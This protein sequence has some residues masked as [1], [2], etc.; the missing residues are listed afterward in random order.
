MQCFDI[1]AFAFVDRIANEVGGRIT[2]LLEQIKSTFHFL[3][4]RLGNRT[5]SRF[6]SKYCVAQISNSHQ[7]C[8]NRGQ[9]LHSFTFRCS[10]CVILH[11]RLGLAKTKYAR[12]ELIDVKAYAAVEAP[13]CR[14]E[15]TKCKFSR[16]LI[17]PLKSTL[18]R[19]TPGPNSALCRTS[20]ILPV[21]PKQSEWASP[22]IQ[23]RSPTFISV[24]LHSLRQLILQAG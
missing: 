24:M 3:L 8:R 11:F 22:R 7:Q 16:R 9:P 1:N 4:E 12:W 21:N 14:L 18:H 17:L 19:W 13:P 5:A 23:T 6:L 10:D 15:R 2:F 20:I